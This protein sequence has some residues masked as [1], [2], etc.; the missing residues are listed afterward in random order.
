VTEPHWTGDKCGLNL[1]I[2]ISYS[3]L[4]QGA[5]EELECD[6]WKGPQSQFYL[7][8]NGIITLSRS[9]AQATR[10][11]SPSY[12]GSSPLRLRS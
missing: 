1:L 3:L 10:W 2:Y 6:S 9:M 5:S 11:G 7:V 8:Q 4:S 12:L